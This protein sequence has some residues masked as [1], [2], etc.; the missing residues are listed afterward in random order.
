MGVNINLMVIRLCVMPDI[1]MCTGEGCELR[2]WC[3]RY[4]A[5]PNGMYQSFMGFYADK[6]PN[7]PCDNFIPNRA[8]EKEGVK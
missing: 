6:N 3:Y 2:K 8:A 1:S 5:Q 7:E 4:T